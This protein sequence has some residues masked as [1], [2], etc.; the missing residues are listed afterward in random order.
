MASRLLP[1]A[2]RAEAD[3]RGAEGDSPGP[4][5]PWSAA[6]AQRH[7]AVGLQGTPAVIDL[8]AVYGRCAMLR[9]FG[10]GFRDALLH[11]GGERARRGVLVDRGTVVVKEGHTISTAYIVYRGALEVTREGRPV[12]TGRLKAG[13]YFGEG[14]LLGSASRHPSTVQTSSLCHL[15]EVTTAAFLKA[16]GPTKALAADAESPE[17]LEEP[18][19]EPQDEAGGRLLQALPAATLAAPEAPPQP[20]SHRATCGGL[21]KAP[22]GLPRSVRHASGRHRGRC[23]GRREWRDS[24]STSPDRSQS[25]SPSES[26]RQERRVQLAAAELPRLALGG[27]SA[28]VGVVDAGD[29]APQLPMVRGVIRRASTTEDEAVIAK[30]RESLRT[31]MRRGFLI[32]VEV[33]E[34]LGLPIGGPRRRQGPQTPAATAVA[35]RDEDDRSGAAGAALDVSLLPPISAMSPLQKGFVQRQLEGRRRRF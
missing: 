16:L 8:G 21:R 24:P 6:I 23:R 20:S 19:E 5:P 4:V 32:P 17:V 15:F 27:G 22:P 35:E 2:P 14:V 33:A 34:Q 9:G 1:P 31:D 13:D 11:W 25:E 28:Q 12:G 10:V 30:V 29:G 18:R 26:P 7:R 3:G